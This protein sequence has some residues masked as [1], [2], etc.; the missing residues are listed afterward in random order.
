[1][2]HEAYLKLV[3]LDRIRWNGR[4]HFFAIASQTM[5]RVLVNYAIERKAQKRGGGQQPK[6]LDDQ[7]LPGG[8][9]PSEELLALDQ[10]LNRLEAVEPRHSRIVECRF[11]GG[12]S[13]A[14]TAEALELS[15][16]TVKRD[17]V[18]ARAWLNRELASQS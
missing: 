8:L 4:A 3:N 13:I 17:W 11:F 9:G 1:M 2:V 16:A 7:E 10:A 18:L 6:A 14:E 15:P 12:M 5:R